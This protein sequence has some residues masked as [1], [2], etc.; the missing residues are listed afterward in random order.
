M[1]SPQDMLSQILLQAP[2][3]RGTQ[4]ELTFDVRA[5][6]GVI[7]SSLGDCLWS[8][9]NHMVYFCSKKLLTF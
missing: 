2:H 4:K 7:K 9:K 1:P 6:N 3:T 8:K 5:Q